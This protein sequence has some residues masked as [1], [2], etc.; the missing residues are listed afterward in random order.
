MCF[1]GDFGLNRSFS[2]VVTHGSQKDVVK[3]IGKYGK[4][5]KKIAAWTG[6]SQNYTR[7][8]QNDLVARILESTPKF[9]GYV[10]S[11]AYNDIHLLAF[12][13]RSILE[14]LAR[15]KFI[16]QS[17]E[18][19]NNWLTE[20]LNDQK[21]IVKGFIAGGDSSSEQVQF[22]QSELERLETFKEKFELSAIKR[23]QNVKDMTEAVDLG[24]DYSTI[25]KL[26]SKIVHPTSL[27]INQSSMLDEFYYH[28][29]LALMVQKYLFELQQHVCD[30][31]EAPESLR[32]K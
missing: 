22:L 10:E 32:F 3:N 6:G 20:A 26:T 19:L 14:N 1:D 9:I 21:D 4:C 31:L 24:F 11:S 8:K 2:D 13:V 25:Y 18:N 28:D 23:P 17:E 27:M 5:I 16:C 29:L 12:G 15:A 7:S 30:V